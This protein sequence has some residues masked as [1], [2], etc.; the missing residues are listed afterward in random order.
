MRAHLKE[1]LNG[2]YT[3]RPAVRP[4]LLP[5]HLRRDGHPRRRS[6]TLEFIGATADKFVLGIIK[7]WLAENRLTDNSSTGLTWDQLDVAVGGAAGHANLT[8]EA[9]ST[10]TGSTTVRRAADAPAARS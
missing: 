9:D 5:R 8:G 10:G 7:L 1:I 2:E 4:G 6:A 3:D